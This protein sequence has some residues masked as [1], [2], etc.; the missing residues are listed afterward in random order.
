[1][2]G[3]DG[4]RAT[5]NIGIVKSA[6]NIYVTSRVVEENLVA[7]SFSGAA[8]VCGIRADEMPARVFDVV[9]PKVR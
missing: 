6:K 4:I 7:A 5:D 9:L 3:N 8:F 1:M 2:I